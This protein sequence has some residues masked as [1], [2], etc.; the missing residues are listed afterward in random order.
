MS[1]TPLAITAKNLSKTYPVYASPLDALKEIFPGRKHHTDF[2]AL[3]DV[4]FDVR[5]GERVGIVGANGAGK[6]TL[7]KVLAGTV[8]HSAGS[9]A[10]NGELRAILELGTGF[11]EECTGRD[12]I[13]MGGLCLGYSAKDLRERTNWIIEFS[14]LGAVMDRPLRT[15]SSGMKM[16]LMY[17]VA[18]CKPV[19][20]M[21]IDEALAT[22]DGAFVRKC[23]NH[24]VEL[25][26]GGATALVV[27]HNLYFLERICHRVIYLRDGRLVADGDPLEVC[28]LYEAEL[29]R[30]FVQGVG[31]PAVTEFRRDDAPDRELLSERAEPILG[32]GRDEPGFVDHKPMLPLDLDPDHAPGEPLKAPTN[33]MGQ[34]REQDG[35]VVPLDFSGAP[36]IRHLGLVRLL[37]ARLFDEQGA[38]TS[39]VGCGR[40]CRVRFVLESRVAKTD[41]HVGFM[42]W[43]QREEHVATSTNVCSLDG[44]GRPNGRRLDLDFGTFAIEVVFPSVRLGAGGYYLKFGVSPGM[45]HYSDDDL[46]LSENRC[47]AFAVVRPDHVQDV[48]YEP[49]SVWSALRPVTAPDALRAGSR[50]SPSAQGTAAAPGVPASA[51]S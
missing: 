43:N 37:E 13:M 41:V 11:H 14:E 33:G 34:V 23:T 4:S 3:T 42:I 16:R 49:H 26:G 2:H 1:S 20:L 10:V 15:Y 8:D 17:S 19:E 40:P 6:S 32:G 24:I 27:S 12:N 46:L 47:L 50:S 38:P 44:L 5:R 31:V 39:E 36:A 45:E 29:A 7:L 35:S 18:F 30:S 21:I 22:G 9:Y 25:C 48:I 28:K 51:Q